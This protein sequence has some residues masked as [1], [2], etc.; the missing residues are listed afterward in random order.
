MTLPGILAE[1]AAATDEA[2]A[3]KVAL[4]FGGQTIKLPAKP[5]ET[6]PLVRCV[7]MADARRI[8][9]AIGHGQVT[10]PMAHLRGQG[11][12]RRAAAK[13]IAEG[14]SISQVARTADMH[15]RTVSLIK[16]RMKRGRLPLF[17]SD[18]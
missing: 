2:V 8:V 7:G 13:L 16:Q 11:A 14:R 1:I 10:I 18:T 12:R 3:A 15:E 17:D 9:E 4:R 5:R 6:S